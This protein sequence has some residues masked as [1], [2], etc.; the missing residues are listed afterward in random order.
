MKNTRISFIIILILVQLGLTQ[1]NTFWQTT[2]SGWSQGQCQLVTSKI[3]VKLHPMYLDI[4]EEAVIKATG[5]VSWGDPKSLEIEGTFTL[6][7]GSAIRSMLL[8]NGNALLKARLITRNLADSAYEEVVDREKQQ[9]IPRDPAII[10]YQ[11]NNTYRYRIYPV[12]INDSRRIRILYTV[13]INTSQQ[14]P[15]FQFRTAFTEG[16][17]INPKQIPVEFSQGEKDL[18]TYQFQYGNTKKSVTTGS[19]YL[20][21]YS[22]FQTK[23]GYN[24]YYYPSSTQI[25][26]FLVIPNYK[27]E[28]RTFTYSSKELD[29]SS[30]TA[31]YSQVPSK[32]REVFTDVYYAPNYS[33]E[34]KVKIE[35]KSY[36][37]DVP[38]DGILTAFLKTKT[39]WDNKIEWNLYNEMGE[40]IQS[41]TQSILPDTSFS[42]YSF[43]PLLWGM[44]YTLEEKKGNTGA[45][46]GFID[47]QMSLLAL[48]SDVLSPELTKLYQEEGMPL[49]SKNEIIIPVS[50]KP[51][52]PKSDISFEVIT[53]NLDLAEKT[54]NLD[55]LKISL[56]GIELLIELQEEYTGSFEAKLFDM[57]GKLIHTWPKG[58]FQNNLAKLAVPS[59]LK[60]VYLLNIQVGNLNQKKQIVLK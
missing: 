23:Y 29:T 53:P 35:S 12:A 33:I 30:Y 56:Q 25:P 49:L 60:G 6:A 20:I 45:L 5:N 42:D 44:R 16:S 21:P 57:N 14:R 43:V 13:P 31:I 34:A 36:L 2:R 59:N 39:P 51:K 22:E 54:L 47:P 19:I 41:Y 8:W 52:L 4:E 10:E 1:N 24:N 40:R 11:G 27:V 28:E 58:N 48:E 7:E 37:F 46:F 18:L 55:K 32:I 15:T 3:K 50:Q 9:L 38:H 26:Y 17:S